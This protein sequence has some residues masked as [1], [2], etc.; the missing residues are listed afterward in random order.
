MITI[1]FGIFSP[2]LPNHIHI[3]IYMSMHNN[4]FIHSQQPLSSLGLTFNL[5][6]LW[7]VF[8]SSIILS[9]TTSNIFTVPHPSSYQ[10]MNGTTKQI[11]SRICIAIF[12]LL[13]I[14]WLTSLWRIVCF[15]ID[16]ALCFQTQNMFH[17]QIQRI[18]NIY[19][20]CVFVCRMRLIL[21]K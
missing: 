14:V 7:F 11:T 13:V 19:V 4:R 2:N 21:N 17:K 5:V 18:R 10:C 9:P 15:V 1:L 6:R 3:Y 20:C 12:F 8:S 16:S